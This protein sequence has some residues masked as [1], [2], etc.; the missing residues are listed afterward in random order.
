MVLIDLFTSSGSETASA[1]T[2]WVDGDARSGSAVAA[3]LFEAFDDPRLQG[4]IGASTVRPLTAFQDPAFF[5]DLLSTVGAATRARPLFVAV[6]G[7]DG[8][9]VMVLPFAL[10]RCGPLRVIEGLD[11]D[12]SDYWAPF[13]TTCR[14]WTGPELEAVWTA[15]RKVLPP[16]DA[17]TLKKVPLSIHGTAHPFSAWQGLKP[18]GAQAVRLALYDEAGAPVAL[19]GLSGVKDGRRKCR[20]LEKTAP[21]V[22][23][24]A[25]EAGLDR[26]LEQMIGQRRER[27]RAIGRPDLMDRPE[28]EIF[29]RQRARAGLADGSVRVF[30]LETEGETLAVIYGL[31][32]GDV[33][34]IVVTSMSSDPRW[35]PASPGLVIMVKAIEWAVA[36]GYR[37]VDL[38]VGAL[39]Y[40]TRFAATATELAEAQFALTPAGLPVVL[41]ATLRRWL[42]H[43]ALRHPMLAR[44]RSALRR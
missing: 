7:P 24:E 15:V 16:A 28:I 36:E 44:L 17:L 27:F 38:S 32:Q 2:D 37:T 13:A 29:Y 9:L 1:T 10:V 40:K 30:A 5:A 35:T 26:M 3:T 11:L 41:V 33:F 42:R 6:T 12:V 21:V 23:R 22:M 18:M 20:R 19:S 34:T 14:T 43:G 8:G 31:C 25:D 39:P 4:L